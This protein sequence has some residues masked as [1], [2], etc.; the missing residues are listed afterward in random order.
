MT[1]ETRSS[2]TLGHLRLPVSDL[3]GAIGFFEAI[4][5][6]RD[7]R[8]EGFAV[9]E[10]RDRTRIQLFQSEKP[11][12][13]SG[14]LQFDFRVEDIDAAWTDY[15][16]KGLEPSD[17]ARRNPGHDWFVLNGPD[18]IEIKINSGFKKG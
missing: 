13:T 1:T 15:K 12:P 9:V 2:V 7:T 14:E 5:G 3:E 10:L 17:I 6:R 4:G 18:G 11:V 8:R 16:A